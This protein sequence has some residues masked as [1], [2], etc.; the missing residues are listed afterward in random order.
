MGL[1]DTNS[2]A[3]PVGITLLR[4]EI[5]RECAHGYVC[6]CTGR[7]EGLDSSGV[8]VCIC[9]NVGGV[10][11]VATQNRR[12]VHGD[13]TETRAERA[14]LGEAVLRVKAAKKVRTW[15]RWLDGHTCAGALGFAA[16]ARRN[17]EHG[18][19]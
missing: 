12:R 16:T 5:E 8:R 9:A 11:T 7:A 15:S 2:C 4:A 17:V 1:T 18:H 14:N 10:A 13:N 3:V 19:R 6:G